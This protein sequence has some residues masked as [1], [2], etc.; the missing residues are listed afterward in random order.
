MDVCDPDAKTENIRKLIKL[1]TGRTVDVS[2]DRI[3]D[4]MRDAKQGNLP[5]PPLV[6]TRDKKYLLDSKSP[7]TQND[8]ETLYK[9]TLSSRDVKRIAKKVGLLNVDRTIS[10]LKNAIGRKLSSVTVREPILLPGS[11]VKR[12]KVINNAFN[13][14]RNDENIRNN[15]ENRNNENR[16]NENRNNENR[17]NENRNNRNRNNENRNSRNRPNINS[18]RRTTN[19]S[20]TI[21]SR[22]ADRL[23]RF[24]NASQNRNRGR[25][26]DKDP[27]RNDRRPE[28][29][30]KKRGFFGR[31]FGGSTN[32]STNKLNT[33]MKIAEIKRNT[34]RQVSHQRA[35]QSRLRLREAKLAKNAISEAERDKRKATNEV[36]KIQNNKHLLEVELN[37]R[38][39]NSR[40]KANEAAQARR[41]LAKEKLHTGEMNMRTANLRRRLR[42][43]VTSL[44]NAVRNRDK[45]KKE[46]NEMKAGGDPAKIKEIQRKISVVDGKIKA[47]EKIKAAAQTAIT[48]MAKRIR[49]DAKLKVDSL[50]KKIETKKLSK[51]SRKTAGLKNFPDE[52]LLSELIKEMEGD[53][54]ATNAGRIMGARGRLK[55]IESFGNDRDLLSNDNFGSREFLKKKD[56]EIAAASKAN[57]GLH[58][59]RKKLE[60]ELAAVKTA[61]SNQFSNGNRKNLQN[62]INAANKKIKNL[63]EELRKKPNTPTPTPSPN[64][65]NTP[66]PTPSPNKPNTPTPSPNKPNT[67]TPSPSPTNNNRIRKLK[68]LMELRSNLHVQVA[69]A[70]LNNRDE[71]NRFKK[72]INDMNNIK[73]KGNIE[74]AIKAAASTAKTARNTKRANAI[75]RTKNEAAKAAKEAAELKARGNIAT[76]RTEAAKEAAAAAQKN[77]NEKRKQ[78]FDNLLTQ[79][80]NVI[81]NSQKSAFQQ[82]FT[83]AQKARETL[84]ANRTNNQKGIIIRGGLAQIAAELRKIKANKNEANHT[85]AIAR[86]KAAGSANEVAKQKNAYLQKRQASFN[87]MVQNAKNRHPLN[88]NQRPR[89]NTMITNLTTKFNRGQEERKKN[90]QQNQTIINAGKIPELAKAV[91]ELE[92][93][94]TQNQRKKNAQNIKNAQENAKKAETNR[95]QAQIQSKKYKEQ[96]E[97]YKKRKNALVQNIKKV[98]ETRNAARK[99]LGQAKKNLDS[100]SSQSKNVQIQAKAN[101]EAART[102]VKAAQNELTKS[103]NASKLANK[104]RELTNLAREQRVLQNL[105]LNNLPPGAVGPRRPRRAFSTIIN[106][107]TVNDLANGGLAGKLPNQIKA[108]GTVKKANQNAK[109]KADMEAAVQRRQEKQETKRKQREAADAKAKA[110]QEKREQQKGSVIKSIKNAQNASK[111]KEQLRQRLTKM[112]TIIT[113]KR[114]KENANRLAREK[115]NKAA[116]N[117]AAKIKEA[118]DKGQRKKEITKLLNNYNNRLG[119]KKWPE[120]KGTL[121]NEYM[122]STKNLEQ[123]KANL[124]ALLKRK[125][126]NAAN[127]LAAKSAAA[128]NKAAEANKTKTKNLENLF[129][130]YNAIMANNSGWP[131]RKDLVREQ[132]RNGRTLER[133]K[134]ELNVMVKFHREKAVKGL[135]SGAIERVKNAEGKALGN[136]RKAYRMKVNG[137]NKAGLFPTRQEVNTLLLQAKTAKNMRTIQGYDKMLNMRLNELKRE[138]NAATKIQ[139]A[140][141]GAQV[142]KSVGGS[143]MGQDILK[144]HISGINVMAGQTIPDFNGKRVKNEAFA[145]YESGW[146]NRVDKEG[147]TAVKRAKLKKM[148]DDKF[149]LKKTLLKHESTNLRTGYGWQQL[150]SLKRQVMRPFS[151]KKYDSTKGTNQNAAILNAARIEKQIKEATNTHANRILKQQPNNMKK[152][153]QKFKTYNNPLGFNKNV[154]KNMTKLPSATFNMTLKRAK[155]SLKNITQKK[156]I[157]PSR[158]AGN[159]LLKAGQITQAKKNAVGNVAGARKAYANQAK[160]AIEQKKKRAKQ[161]VVN[162][163]KGKAGKNQIRYM[164]MINTGQINQAMKEVDRKVMQHPGLKIQPKLT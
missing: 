34:Q 36:T 161:R 2:R 140:V 138:K 84:N 154:P 93:E 146:L 50:K 136:A 29:R 88:S 99:E 66:T 4:I 46:L 109:K 100:A 96:S 57:T 42:T 14:V 1:H 40:K 121:L 108:T 157:R 103:K 61:F 44:N 20:G 110:N 53:P 137:G 139:A 114:A 153:G 83:N 6:L 28:D 151:S 156:I 134:D 124:E 26:G 69:R 126:K 32:T 97:K 72:R 101:L 128:T 113:E 78:K 27:G 118:V 7:L 107:L 48:S 56:E 148:F 79:F 11:R 145:K 60:N 120:T 45:L 163:L 73:Q 111:A 116:A 150:Q 158:M 122:K 65:P 25:V 164:K 86:A 141:K 17:N 10:E 70:R 123:D 63:E 74:N 8:Y 91:R 39:S 19:V 68:E 55:K 30:P 52:G 160:F 22:H 16:N 38:A 92:N 62:R 85:A 115:A 105:E 131:I 104:K 59:D 35:I 162:S 24:G 129:S 94:F 117:K 98:V 67:P 155:P 64:K 41:E 90:G 159:S 132:Y 31:L 142:R 51:L 13:N 77:R 143:S 81:N 80:K 76:A 119:S 95:N 135:V 125:V 5:L 144:K 149:E 12:E 112:K 82:R 89:L 21:R 9:S 49:N 47:Q 152:A 71:E 23:K 102:A 58:A 130:K 43:R 15:N 106:G 54:T 3:C 75:Q 37:K 147:D 33:Q 18:A 127:N 133:I 87:K